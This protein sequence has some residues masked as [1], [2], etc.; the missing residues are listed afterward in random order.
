MNDTVTVGTNDVD[1]DFGMNLEF[2]RLPEEALADGFNRH[3]VRENE[4]GSLD[5]RFA[6]MEP[7][8]RKGFD[9]T[10]DF[11]RRVTS[12]DY[13]RIPL[14]LD[15]SKNQ[16]A[17]VGYIEPDNINFDD[18]MKTQVHIPN[19]GSSIRDDVIADFT[20]DP[21]QI[22]DIS[23]S[24]DPRTVELEPPKSRDDN[25]EFV[26]ARIREFSLTPFPG[27]YDNGGITP[28]FSSAIEQASLN[29]SDFEEPKSQLITRPHT[30]IKR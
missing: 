30:L 19:T 4:D 2:T 9:V 7:G 23:V 10:D 22:Q 29:P 24:F 11:L 17:N 21:P 20:H 18:I 3:G 15:H 25:P 1:G 14:Q 27:G 16:R 28:E 13:S 5:V 26:D 8:E 12:H 6:A